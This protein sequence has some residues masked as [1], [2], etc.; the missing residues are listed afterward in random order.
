ME[1]TLQ[2][3]LTAVLQRTRVLQ[4]L[5][6]FH[7]SVGNIYSSCLGDASCEAV[8]SN[9]GSMGYLDAGC[10]GEFSCSNAASR[11]GLIDGIY[12]ACNEARSCESAAINAI[13]AQEIINCCNEE[14]QCQ[15][16]ISFQET[17]CHG[18][19][20]T[21]LPTVTSTGE[22]TKGAK[23]IPVDAA[24][25]KPT[26]KPPPTVLSPKTSVPTAYPSI[27]PVTSKSISPSL[28]LN[29]SED[30]SVLSFGG[31]SS[32]GGGAL[33]VSLKSSLC[34]MN[35]YYERI[36]NTKHVFALSLS[37][38]RVSTPSHPSP[39]HPSPSDLIKKSK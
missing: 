5:P 1:D 22:P 2:E 33:T 23:D 24:T 9:K 28:S 36:N 13:I 34:T 8:A 7:G 21:P 15:N 31:A 37:I 11:G 20:P 38:Y 26:S 32:V 30:L 17:D 27:S 19:R 35:R 29:L 12:M 3:S 25:P 14:A 16:I 10:G 6:P 4:W 18:D 39:S